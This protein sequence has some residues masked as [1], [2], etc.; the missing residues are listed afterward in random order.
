[1]IIENLTH[2]DFVKASKL[3]PKK[4]PFDAIEEYVKTLS[5]LFDIPNIDAKGC[6]FIAFSITN[7]ESVSSYE[8]TKYRR[9][10]EVAAIRSKT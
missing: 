4:L 3:L 6:L 1:M 7:G 10:K 8:H 2:D 9:I 5:E